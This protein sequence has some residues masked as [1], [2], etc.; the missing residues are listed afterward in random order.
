MCKDKA[1][2]TNLQ[3]KFTNFLLLLLFQKISLT[4]FFVLAIPSKT[5]LYLNIPL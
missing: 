1:N 2:Y 4:L 5:K 3:Q